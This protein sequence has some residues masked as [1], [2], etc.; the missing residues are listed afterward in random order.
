MDKIEVLSVKVYKDGLT[1]VEL[2]NLETGEITM[3]YIPLSGSI[4]PA[5]AL[6]D[7]TEVWSRVDT[8]DIKWI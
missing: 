7:S 4:I 8:G 1:K 5:Y 6:T 2:L 3:G